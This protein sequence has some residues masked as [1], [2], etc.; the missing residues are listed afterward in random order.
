MKIPFGIAL[1]VLLTL[2]V[3]SGC[4]PVY[5][6]PG[7]AP[8]PNVRLAA[9]QIRHIPHRC[10]GYRHYIRLANGRWLIHTPA[11]ARSGARHIAKTRDQI[12]SRD[13]PRSA[14]KTLEP[15]WGAAATQ[16]ATPDDRTERLERRVKVI[17]EATIE[18]LEKVRKFQFDDQ[19]PAPPPGE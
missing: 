8:H 14:Y 7:P 5:Y 18:I 6:S 15:D 17:G 2:A 9:S 13:V 16:P 19:A 11:L 1:L 3:S 10:P 12:P 4:V